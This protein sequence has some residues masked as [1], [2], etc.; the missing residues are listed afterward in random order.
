MIRRRGRFSSRSSFQAEKS[1]EAL[2]VD[3][4]LTPLALFDKPDPL[5]GPYF[6][7]TL[8]ITPSR[9][10]IELQHQVF[11]TSA[12]AAAAP[13]LRT[14]PMHAELRLNDTGAWNVEVAARSIG[15]LCSNTLRFGDGEHSRLPQQWQGIGGPRPVR[16]GGRRDRS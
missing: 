2:L 13:G 8:Y 1:L 11:D 14:G 7:E 9:L 5:D 6:E 4:V 3:G 16:L 12:S 15:G 10:R